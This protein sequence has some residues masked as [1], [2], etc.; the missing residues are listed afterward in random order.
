A[1]ALQRRS[2]APCWTLWLPCDARQPLP[3]E[4]G[5]TAGLTKAP[6]ARPACS[7]SDT[8]P[9]IGEIGYDLQTALVG[10]LA[11]GSG[12]YWLTLPQC[13]AALRAGIDLITE[14]GASGYSIHNFE[15]NHSFGHHEQSRD[16]AK[17]ERGPNQSW[18]QNQRY[19]DPVHQLAI[20]L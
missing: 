3:V 15:D 17:R 5:E 7:S 4:A 10:V 19:N 2:W 20:S 11:A 6:L 9:S 12:S 8:N 18:R 16:P 14:H 13:C 1:R